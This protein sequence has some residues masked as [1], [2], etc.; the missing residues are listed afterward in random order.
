MKTSGDETL[1]AIAA[2]AV[3]EIGYHIRRSSEWIIRLGD[4]TSESHRKIQ[5]AID[6]LWM[7]T[8]ELFEADEVDLD[9]MKKNMAPDL[10]TIKG[11]WNSHVNGVLEMAKL[12]RPE[13]EYA[14]TGGKNGRHTEHLGH[15]LS[16]MQYLQRAY[17]DA[18]W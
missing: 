1:A 12:Q 9:L 5:S 6:E 11:Q 8:G 18:S 7:F 2:K 14:L 4:G 10:K 13:N 16:E 17:P 3:K 15:M